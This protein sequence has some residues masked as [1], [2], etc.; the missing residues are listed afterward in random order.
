MVHYKHLC[1]GFSGES[2]ANKQLFPNFLVRNISIHNSAFYSYHC[3]CALPLWRG[4]FPSDFTKL[5][6][7]CAHEICI[8]AAGV[9]PAERENA[10][11]QKRENAKHGN[12]EKRKRENAKMSKETKHIKN[13]TWPEGCGQR[14]EKTR[15]REN[16]KTEKTEK[17]RKRE[18]ENQKTGPLL[19][20]FGFSSFSPF[21]R[22]RVFAFSPFSL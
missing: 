1:I 3:V 7:C 17:T 4:C 14:N 22:F 15:K 10:K 8:P 13:A 11:T 12:G 18:I 2:L 16:Q 6:P 9:R 20:V 5:S 19:A 21:S